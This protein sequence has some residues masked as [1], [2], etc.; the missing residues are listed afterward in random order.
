MPPP[1]KAILETPVYVDDLDQA[2]GF[3]HELLGLERMVT[4][5]RIHAYDVAPGQ[6]LI[7]CDRK[8]SQED[9]EIG[10][11]RVPG[12]GATGVGH[13]AFRIHMDALVDWIAYLA[14]N[15]VAIESRVRWPLGGESLY[16]RDPSDNIVE[17]ATGGV[18][19]ND[20]DA[21]D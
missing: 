5:E 7:V 8:A 2:Y 21:K 19:P 20:P 6:V 10:G 16:F 14:E 13:F 17:L 15:R 11:A 9:A 3:Y 12:H 4:G 1:I 18:W